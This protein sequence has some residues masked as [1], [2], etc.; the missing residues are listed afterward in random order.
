[1]IAV[2]ESTSIEGRFSVG[3]FMILE[4]ETLVDGLGYFFSKY[5]L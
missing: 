2:S 5:F 1:M 3:S 4:I